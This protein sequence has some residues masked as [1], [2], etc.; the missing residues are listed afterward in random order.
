MLRTEN[1]LRDII[2]E[3]TTNEVNALT[4]RNANEN[5]NVKKDMKHLYKEMTGSMV[6]YLNNGQG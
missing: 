1:Q 5:K 3:T 4:L 2:K 6:S